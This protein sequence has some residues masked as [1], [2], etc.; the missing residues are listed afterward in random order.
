[1]PTIK[2]PEGGM[3]RIEYYHPYEYFDRKTLIG[4]KI[5]D[6]TFKLQKIVRIKRKL[7]YDVF[8]KLYWGS[9]YWSL[10]RDSLQYVLDFTKQN[11]KALRSMKFTI[12]SEEIYFQTIL[13]NSEYIEKTVNDNLRYIDWSSGRYGSPAFL[14]ITDYNKI[15]QSNKLFARK[16]HEKYSQELKKMLINKEF[17]NGI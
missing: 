1:M 5:L 2:L 11:K 12:C 6:Y 7:P 8:H 13:L 4:K 17:S 16:F 14:D 9:T 3:D 10:T 15:K